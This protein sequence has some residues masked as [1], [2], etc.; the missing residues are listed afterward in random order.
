MTSVTAFFR[1]FTLAAG[2]LA[3]GMLLP[4]GFAWAQ[5]A[6]GGDPQGLQAVIDTAM[7][8]GNPISA[9]EFNAVVAPFFEVEKA[10]AGGFQLALK[11][12]DADVGHQLIVRRLPDSQGTDVIMG[13]AT[14]DSI[15]GFLTSEDGKLRDAIRRQR[16]AD[17]D[18]TITE[19]TRTLFASE[20]RFWHAWVRAVTK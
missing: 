4:A 1:R 2:V 18:F 6:E 9:E 12:K 16:G 8:K 15:T 13:Y 11:P 7:A 17:S 20:K 14:K 19:E 5:S 3:A 10:D